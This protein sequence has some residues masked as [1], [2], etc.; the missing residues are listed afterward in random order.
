MDYKFSPEAEKD[1]HEAFLWYEE[2]YAGL[3]EKFVAD[4]KSSI[5]TILE[6][7]KGWPLVGKYTRRCLLIKYPYI[8][9]YTYENNEIY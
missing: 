6:Y 3:G 7:P 8:L 2:Q 5:S 4:I 9:L 1:L